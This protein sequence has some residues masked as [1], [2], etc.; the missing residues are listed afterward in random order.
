ML[1]A[2]ICCLPRGFPSCKVGKESFC[3][4]GDTGGVGLIPGLGRSSGG[5]NGSPLPYSCLENPM[6]RGAWW[7]TVHGVVKNRI[8]LSMMNCL[9]AK[10]PS[11]KYFAYVFVLTLKNLMK[12]KKLNIYY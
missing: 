5:G 3:N 8:Q 7:T 6:D 9:P 10:R 12:F 2:T 4:A 1:I 11:V